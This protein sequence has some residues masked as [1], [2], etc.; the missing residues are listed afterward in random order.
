MLLSYVG[1]QSVQRAFFVS[2]LNFG[3]NDKLQFVSIEALG[4]PVRR[5]LTSKTWEQ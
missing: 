2:Q 1:G 3:H 4:G 5:F